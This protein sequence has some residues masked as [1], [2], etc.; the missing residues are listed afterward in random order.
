MDVFV[1]GTLT[2]PARVASVVDSYAFLGSAV[3]DG[4]HPVEGEHPT[5]APGGRTGGRLL[6]T[7]DAAALDR[8]EGVASG[9][10]VRV[11][12]PYRGDDREEVFVYVGDPARLGADAEWPGRGSLAD[13]VE[14]YVESEGVTV[15]PTS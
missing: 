1:Y 7:D 15:S 8:Y 11:P 5:L 12:V 14:R 4:L 13:R 10:Y 6:R 9:L 3:L 2:D